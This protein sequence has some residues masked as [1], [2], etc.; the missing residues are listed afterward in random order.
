M[1]TTD[2]YVKNE[3]FPYWINF[4]LEILNHLSISSFDNT[5]KSWDGL[6]RYI[7]AFHKV[8]VAE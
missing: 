5:I 4:G 8:M 3:L 1:T 7:L 2:A 6:D